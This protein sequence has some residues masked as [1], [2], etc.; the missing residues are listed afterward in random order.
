MEVN[1]N[2][3]DIEEME[4]LVT[5][6]GK[7]SKQDIC[8]TPTSNPKAK[9]SIRNSAFL[10]CKEHD[11]SKTWSDQNTNCASCIKYISCENLGNGTLP[12]GKDV[13]SFLLSLK[14]TNTGKTKSSEHECTMDLVLHWIYCNV[15]PLSIASVKRRINLM[16]ET[17]NHL[18]KYPNKKKGDAYWRK[19]EDFIQSQNSLFN[20]I[21]KILNFL[22]KS[23]FCVHK[24]TRC[25]P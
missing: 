1:E 25:S 8:S 9:S 7:Y 22:F 11:G 20:I 12:R 19:F 6:A 4:L 15:Y 17:Y 21:G 3:H 5:R 24:N 23:Y 2:V 18:K 14:R 10:K 13:L 16:V